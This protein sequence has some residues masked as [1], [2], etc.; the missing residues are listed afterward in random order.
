[1]VQVT[2]A[3]QAL[4]LDFGGVVIKTP[5]EILAALERRLRIAPGTLAWYGPFAPERD[6][7]WQRMQRDEIS[8]REYWAMRAA[9]TGRAA[10]RG[11]VMSTYELMREMYACDE[12]DIVRPE[13]IEAIDAARAAGIPVAVLTNDLAAFHGPAW[14]PS[15][16]I[17]KH[18]TLVV[19]G[20]V[21]GVLKPDPAA[22]ADVAA[23]LDMLASRCIFVDDQVRNV[24][25]AESAAMLAEHFDVTAPCMSFDRVLD[26][27]TLSRTTSGL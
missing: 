8:E 13:A 12:S 5:F 18:I 1:M 27:L 25:G 15:L 14:Y 23:R 9:E 10:G 2:S 26:R 22:Y 4:V 24:R 19:D 6:Q 21:T 3:P 16:E 7:L 11:G 17:S 20:S